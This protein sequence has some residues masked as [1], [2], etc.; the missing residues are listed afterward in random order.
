MSEWP[1]GFNFKS[2]LIIMSYKAK[3][4]I[5]HDGTLYSPGDEIPSNKM[6]SETAEYHRAAGRIEDI[7]EESS[8]E[9]DKT[10]KELLLAENKS[11]TEDL[12]KKAG[13]P[14]EEWGDLNKEPLIDYY[15]A[16]QAEASEEEE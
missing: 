5:R 4:Y 2:I 15:L 8:A 9:Q 3:T 1:A 16:K 10:P 13:Y 11:H 12:C 14:E 7:K 6:D